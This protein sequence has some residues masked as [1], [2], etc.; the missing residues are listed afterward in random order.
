MGPDGYQTVREHVERALGG[1]EVKYELWM[2]YPTGVRRVH[3][4][5]PL[6][7]RSGAV[8]GFVALVQDISSEQ[9]REE[10]LKFPRRGR[11]RCS[12]RRSTTRRRSS[13][14]PA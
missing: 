4:L 9:R 8:D 11:C 14:S 12:P 3:Q 1:A 2:P 6:R 10:K 5:M 13:A 7:T